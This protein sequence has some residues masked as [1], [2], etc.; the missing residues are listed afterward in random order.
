M[1]PSLFNEI[2]EHI[3]IVE[4]EWTDPLPS[5]VVEEH[6]GFQ[7]VRIF[8]NSSVP[9]ESRL[10]SNTSSKI[11]RLQF[12]LFFNPATSLHA[13]NKDKSILNRSPSLK[14]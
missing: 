5:P 14:L 13:N 3:N 2:E 8:R 7:V 1:T 9:T 12:T 4:R 10:E 11:N 6:E